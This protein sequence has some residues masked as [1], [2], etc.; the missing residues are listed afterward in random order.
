MSY[1][2]TANSEFN[3]KETK[4]ELIRIVI[5]IALQNLLVAIVGASDVIMLGFLN[6]ESLSA[7]NLAGQIMQIFNFIVMAL[8]VGTTALAAQYYGKNDKAA[9]ERVFYTALQFYLS[10]GSVFTLCC[11]ILPN[12]IMQ[13]FTADPVLIS[14]GAQ[15]LRYIS[16][17]FILMGFSQ[18]YMIIMKNT[19]DVLKSTIFG[20]TSVVLNIILNAILI[21]GLLG[22]PKLGILG[23]AIA[24]TISKSVEFL[25]TFIHSLQNKQIHLK[26][27]AIF[28]NYRAMRTKYLRYTLPSIIQLGSW[29]VATSLT[30]A[31]IGHI[32]SSA[33]AAN[34]VALLI[35]NIAASFALG[36]GTG[37]GI[38]LGGLLGVGNLD[39]AKKTG[40]Y[41]LTRTLFISPIIS[42]LVLLVIPLI[43]YLPFS[44]S[45]ESLYYLKFMLIV[46]AIK[47]I[48]K[49]INHTLATGIFSA[50]GDI[51]FLMKLD[52]IN[53]WC[54][55]LPLGFIA[56]FILKLPVVVVYIILNM[57]EFTKMY[58]E[59][60][61]YLQYKWV[62]NLTKK[63]W[64]EPGKF[65]KELRQKIVNDMPMGVMMVGSSG[66][67]TMT[68][69][70]L[71]DILGF[72]GED[73]EGE[74]FASF[75]LTDP[76]N[77]DFTEV[78]VDSI[79]DKTT[80][81]EQLVDYY[82]N[83][84]QKKLHLKTIFIEEEDSNIGILVM[85]NDL[86]P[87]SLELKTN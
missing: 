11:L 67:I 45:A 59:I 41:I 79:Y 30:V 7:A 8:S 37:A 53:M 23:A 27:A 78:I 86:T 39:N 84:V 40:D 82:S 52:I 5:P 36:Y 66:K 42:I 12:Q 17:I 15:Y 70:A 47:I 54:I 69:K 33:V 19:G 20:G 65:D 35:F 57:D 85:I 55:I 76:R 24:T 56:A 60:K 64:A 34:A 31:I 29:Q 71:L 81:K 16:I 48:G 87:I 4:S 18:V 21:F 6:E 83:D 51:K 58:S 72:T 62:K 14:L 1:A 43:P 32:S 13:I 77:N 44:L 25:L 49:C 73:I 61:H 50:G 3:K 74:T 9:V 2:V 26:F 38:I 68:N 22:F 46:T 28:K 63:E 80:A 75:F 10:I